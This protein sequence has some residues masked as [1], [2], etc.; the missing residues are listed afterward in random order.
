MFLLP[1]WCGNNWTKLW[2]FYSLFVI[3]QPNVHCPKLYPNSPFVMWLGTTRPRPQSNI[4]TSV[5]DGMQC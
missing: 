4:A 2:V 1:S 3:T 5:L